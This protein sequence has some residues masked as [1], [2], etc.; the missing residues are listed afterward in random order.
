ME[1]FSLIVEDNLRGKCTKGSRCKG[2]IREALMLIVS[3]ASA[4]YSKEAEDK[5]K[6]VE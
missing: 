6:E 3:G 1:I 2:S 5:A 4:A